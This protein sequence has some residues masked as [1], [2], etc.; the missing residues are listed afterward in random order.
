MESMRSRPLFRLGRAVPAQA[1]MTVS[2]ASRLLAAVLL[3]LIAVD[4][5][6]DRTQV[7]AP[8]MAALV[9]GTCAPVPDRFRGAMGG[10]GAG[11]AF[12]A[13]TVLTHL[14][15]GIGALLAGLVA[16]AATFAWTSRRDGHT[17]LAAAA[18]LASA[19]VMGALLMAIF[20]AVEG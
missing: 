11:L 17:W 1:A 6:Y 9:A 12:F 16:A 18:F 13:G 7:F 20:F 4:Q 14:G 2:V 19:G 5:S 10:L 3:L 8:V 15:P